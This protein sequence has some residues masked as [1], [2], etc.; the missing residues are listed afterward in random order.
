MQP[1]TATLTRKRFSVSVFSH[2]RRVPMDSSGSQCSL[3]NKRLQ[4][5]LLSMLK[6]PSPGVSINPDTLHGSHSLT[7]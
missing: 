4:K 5:E 6:E 1:L 7:Q 2:Y 3:L